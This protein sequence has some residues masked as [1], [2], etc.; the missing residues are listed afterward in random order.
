MRYWISNGA[1]ITP[2]VQKLLNVGGLMNPAWVANG[3]CTLYPKPVPDVQQL[4]YRRAE[5][6]RWIGYTSELY[7]IAREQEEE[8]ILLR[9]MKEDRAVLDLLIN[10]IDD[11]SLDFK[12]EDFEEVISDKFIRSKVFYKLS[13][14]LDAVEKKTKQVHPGTRKLLIS[15]LEK[16][17]RE[18]IFSKKEAEKE[19]KKYKNSPD[20]T[21]EYSACNTARY[22]KKIW[23]KS[24]LIQT[25]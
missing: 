9:K 4:H 5:K 7:K 15:R 3:R 23:V 25:C 13:D 2:K 1:I 6:D 11:Q 8:D 12:P 16:Y 24:Y 14:L 22:V 21:R 20:R 10:R 18:G 17:S 19:W